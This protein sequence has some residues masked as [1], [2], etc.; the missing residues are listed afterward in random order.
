MGDALTKFGAPKILLHF[1]AQRQH[2]RLIHDPKFE[3]GKKVHKRI[4]EQKIKEM[5]GQE[6]AF[7]CQLKKL[8]SKHNW[9]WDAE[10]EVVRYP[11]LQ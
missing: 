1:F 4:L 9:P 7:V 6:A 5:E 8:A 10:D 11:P 2:W 3:A